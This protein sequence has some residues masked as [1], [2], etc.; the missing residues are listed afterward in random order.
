MEFQSNVQLGIRK[1]KWEGGDDQELLRE[2]ESLAGRALALS[3][4]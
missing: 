2:G 1:G 3:W 4:G